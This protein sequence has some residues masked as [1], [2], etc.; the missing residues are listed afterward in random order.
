MERKRKAE[1][2]D[3][4]HLKGNT[5]NETACYKIEG[6][7]FEVET[8]CGGSELLCDKMTRLTNRKP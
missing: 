1:R 5:L 8:S 3:L 2:N 7:V 4:L 6:T